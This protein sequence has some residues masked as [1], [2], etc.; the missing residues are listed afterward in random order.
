MEEKVKGGLGK[1]SYVLGIIAVIFALLPVLSP[2]FLVISWLVYVVG[3]VGAILGAIAIVKK[4]QKAII[5]TALCVGAI[6]V[7]MI[8][9]RSDWMAKRS[10]ESAASAI[11]STM[12]LANKAKAL[13]EDEAF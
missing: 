3:I 2:W 13:S 8:L 7:F 1:A 5:G 6:V 12:G 9:V 11:E 10:A 4:H